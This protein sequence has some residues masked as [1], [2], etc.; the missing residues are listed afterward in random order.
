VGVKVANNEPSI[1]VNSTSKSATVA[2]SASA[3]SFEKCTRKINRKS[4]VE[5]ETT[6]WKKE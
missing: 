4:F 5:I 6:T 2:L 1:T 3:G